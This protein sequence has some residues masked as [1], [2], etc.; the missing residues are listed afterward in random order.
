VQSHL[1]Y[2]NIILGIFISFW[3]KLFFR[4]YDYNIFEILIAMCFYM[5]IGMLIFTVFA[6]ISILVPFD[7]VKIGGI[8]GFIYCAWAIGQ[9][10]DKNKFINY[11]KA[12]F[13]YTLGMITFSLS[14]FLVAYVIDLIIKK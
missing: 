3:I 2:S 12:L 5:G 13:A 11:L 7:V 10:F 6:I 9:F 8:F 14:I 4:K 1:G